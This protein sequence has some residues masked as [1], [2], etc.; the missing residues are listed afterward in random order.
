MFNNE[1]INVF[2]NKHILMLSIYPHWM[3]LFFSVSKEANLKQFVIF[4][5]SVTSYKFNNKSKY[6]R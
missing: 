1:L 3:D 2:V 6:R 4:I 5:T